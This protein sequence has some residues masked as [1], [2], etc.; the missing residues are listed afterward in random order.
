[1]KKIIL[2]FAVGLLFS[3][4]VKDL[5]VEPLDKDVVTSASVLMMSRVI[6]KFGKDICRTCCLRTKRS[7][8]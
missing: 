2:L 3:S 5:D 4:C 8:R 6:I 1:M 7:F